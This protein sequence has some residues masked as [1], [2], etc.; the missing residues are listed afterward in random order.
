MNARLETGYYGPAYESEFHDEQDDDLP[1]SQSEGISQPLP[2][3]GWGPQ[4]PR[5]RARAGGPRAH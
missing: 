1:D 5:L 4:P 2:Y 3:D